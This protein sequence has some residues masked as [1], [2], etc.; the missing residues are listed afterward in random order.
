MIKRTIKLAEIS[1]VKRPLPTAETP[2]IPAYLQQTYWWAYLH[3]RAVHFFERS[4]L[5]NLILLGNYRRLSGI[6]LDA[7]GDALDGAT[8]Q[9]ACVYGDFTEQL[10]RRLSACGRL[11][12]VD[13]LPI[14][15]VNLARKLPSD[16]RVQLT[17]ANA[18]NI[19]GEAARY[20]RAVLFFLL[21]EQPEAVRRATLAEV[22]RL[23]KPG[24][25]IVIIDYHCPDWWQPLRWPLAAVLQ[26]LEPYALDLWRHELCLFL[27]APAH[28]LRQQTYY[29]GIYQLL[30]LRR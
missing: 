17:C 4:W 9:V 1:V 21:H 6:A 10:R 8:L 15:L 27:P 24:G 3:P 23:V 5:I 19:G 30:E 25:S 2:L 16:P 28:I 13:V 22:W 11:E 12:V 18:E 20:E 7:L 26:T 29:G 14:Q